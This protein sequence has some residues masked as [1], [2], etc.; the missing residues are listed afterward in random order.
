MKLLLFFLSVVFSGAVSGA[1]EITVAKRDEAYTH[2]QQLIAIDNDRRMNLY[3]I[4]SGTPVVIFDSGLSDWGFTWALVQPEVSKTTRACVYDRAGLGYSDA[5]NRPG[6]SANSVGD[7]HKLLVAASIKPPYL[8]VG[9]SLGGLNIRLYTDLFPTE[10]AGMVLVDPIHEDGLARLDIVTSGKESRRYKSLVKRW[11]DCTAA[12]KAG[13]SPGTDMFYKC[14]DTAEPRYSKALNAA[15]TTVE[16]RLSF[17][18]AQLS[19]TENFLNG[20]SFAE[21]RAARRSYGRMPLIVLTSGKE[22]RAFGPEWKKLHLEL[23]ALSAVGVQRTITNA[24]HYIQIDRPDEVIA[25]IAEV[26][27]YIAQDKK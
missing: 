27:K 4:G 24:G 9:H 14:I 6:T 1:R 19:E 17:Q 12:A 15:R 20:I 16:R 21:A 11:R 3:C 23:A 18:Q 26:I 7:L 10:V 5:A 8:L 25:A 13:L 22:L 2:P